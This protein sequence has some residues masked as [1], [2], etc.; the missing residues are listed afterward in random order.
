MTKTL[1]VAKELGA[2]MKSG[3][4]IVETTVAIDDEVQGT[5][6]KAR[7]TSRR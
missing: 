7:A 6:C 5:V 3:G 1:F 4:S 2:A